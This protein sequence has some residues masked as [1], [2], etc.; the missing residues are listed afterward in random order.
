MMK[1]LFFLCA[2]LFVSM[3]IQAQ[4]YIVTT[5]ED[6]DYNN[7]GLNDEP[8]TDLDQAIVIHKPDGE[9]IIIEID[10]NEISASE[11]SG[12]SGTLNDN[13]GFGYKDAYLN[14]RLNIE[15]NAIISEGY[16]LMHIVATDEGW[17]GR[18]YYLSVP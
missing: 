9:S 6:F 17:N 5:H 13:G 7:S 8:Y 2:F 3:Q 14:Q 10:D 1:K 11:I 4:L 18:R 15:L 16:T 12:Y